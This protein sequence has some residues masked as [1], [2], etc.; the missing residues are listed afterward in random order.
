MDLDSKALFF[1]TKFL[2]FISFLLMHIIILEED[3]AET[4]IIKAID[5]LNVVYS[6]NFISFY[7]TT[8]ILE[9]FYYLACKFYRLMLSILKIFNASMHLFAN[10]YDS[11]SVL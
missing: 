6:L 10:F 7:S 1:I 9:F 5:L 2:E 4:Y 8:Q 11:E 3:L